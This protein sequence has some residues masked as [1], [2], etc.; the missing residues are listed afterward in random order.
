M[1]NNAITLPTPT[2][3]TALKML[4]RRSDPPPRILVYPD[5][6]KTFD[7][8]AWVASGDKAFI[9]IVPVPTLMRM[10]AHQQPWELTKNTWGPT[11]EFDWGGKVWQQLLFW[12]E[13]GD[14]SVSLTMTPVLG[15]SQAQG[16]CRVLT[17][18]THYWCIQELFARCASLLTKPY[19]SRCTNPQ[20]HGVLR[21][22]IG[23]REQERIPIAYVMAVSEFAPAISLAERSLKS[24]GVTT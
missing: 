3:A 12:A 9:G 2:A 19:W 17:D 21:A 11:T 5:I 10:L 8:G 24:G 18:E 20:F 6:G 23:W 1:A 13:E 16:L 14:W 22:S 7:N 4:A 15:T